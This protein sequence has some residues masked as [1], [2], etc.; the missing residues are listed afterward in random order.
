[1]KFFKD[2]IL[3][4]ISQDVSFTKLLVPKC[5]IMLSRFFFS[6]G[7]R[8]SYISWVAAPGKMRTLTFLYPDI[9]FCSISANIESPTIR[10]VPIF[11]CLIELI[12]YTFSMV[13]YSVSVGKRFSFFFPLTHKTSS[14]IPFWRHLV[15][16]WFF[17]LLMKIFP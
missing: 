14:W 6:K 8:Y 17:L 11:Y 2:N 5:K 4:K 1:M 9:R 12:F 13:K 3:F 16:C 15:G 10:V 7:F